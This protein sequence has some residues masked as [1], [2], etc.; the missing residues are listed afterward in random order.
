VACLPFLQDV[1]ALLHVTIIVSGMARNVSVDVKTQQKV[2]TPVNA[3]IEQPSRIAIV[4]SRRQSGWG[5]TLWSSGVS[6][7][8]LDSILFWKTTFKSFLSVQ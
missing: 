1:K 8:V 7:L 6:G 3:P 5:S 4:T 2:A